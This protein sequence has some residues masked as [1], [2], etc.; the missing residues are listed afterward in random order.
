M[1]HFSFVPHVKRD[2]AHPKPRA[3]PK[4]RRMLSR[5]GYRA[6]SRVGYRCTRGRAACGCR[7]APRCPLSPACRTRRLQKTHK[8]NCS[9]VLPRRRQRVSSAAVS[10]T[11][12]SSSATHGRPRGCRHKC[13][14][15]AF[16]CHV[17]A[18]NTCCYLGTSCRVYWRVATVGY[19]AHSVGY[20]CHRAPAA[21]LSPSSH[22]RSC[23]PNQTRPGLPDWSACAHSKASG[24]PVTDTVGYLTVRYCD[25]LVHL[26]IWSVCLAHAAAC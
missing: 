18:C 7:A 8:R 17:V 19:G 10:S 15:C 5:V 22:P 3:R 26:L 4:L 9:A 21:W 1:L 25:L 11:A 16:A 23:E 14:T 20:R 12:D 24:I 13:Q 6:G 2:W